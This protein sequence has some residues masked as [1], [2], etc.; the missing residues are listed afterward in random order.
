MSSILEDLNAPQREAV[1]HRDGPM[2]VVAGAGSGKTR[3]V[4]RRIAHLIGQGVPPRRILALTF[5]NKAAREMADRVEKLVGPAKTLVTTFH[6]ACARFLRFD[7]ERL[8]CGRDRRFSIY[9]EADQEAIIKSAVREL[10]LD[11]KQWPSRKL[12]ASISRFKTD[13]VGFEDALAAAY[14]PRQELAA[15]VY[16]RYEKKLREANALDFDDLLWVMLR[17]FQSDKPL[18]SEYQERYPDLL[19]DEYQDTNRV[20]YLLLKA[21][22]GERRNLHATGDPDQ[23]I[24]SWRGA[25]YRNIMDFAR[26]YPGTRLVLLEENYRS[27][28]RILN[29]S[30]RLIA[31]NARRYEKRLFTS[32]ALGEPVRLAHLPD[33]RAEAAWVAAEVKALARAGRSLREVAVFYRVNAQ[34]QPF[35]EVFMRETLPYAL[36]GGVRFYERREIKDL[37]AYLKAIQ[38]PRDNVSFRRLAASPPKGV[39]EKTLAALEALANARGQGMEAVLLREDFSEIWTGRL[40]AKLR[41]LRELCRALAGLPRAPVFPLVERVLALSGLKEHYKN[42]A[43]PRSDER[44]ENIEALVN[45]AAEF[46][47]DRPG[48]DLAAFLE[49]VALV[50]DVDEWDDTADRLTLMTMHAAKGL[51][52]AVVFVVGVE[53][54]LLPYGTNVESEAEKEEER[55]LFYVAMTRAREKLY[56]SA[57]A[58]RLQWGQVTVSLPSEFL[59]ELPEEDVEEMC[60]EDEAPAAAPELMPPMGGRA[61]CL[62]RRAPVRQGRRRLL[63]AGQPRRRQFEDLDEPWDETPLDLDADFAPGPGLG[64]GGDGDPLG[65]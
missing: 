36:V 54:R 40:S 57:A 6:S 2:L 3:V 13:M 23:S 42:L 46:D 29:V 51:E 41:A 55:R 21:L 39:G 10:D 60:L 11:S 20:Q 25:D 62:G 12:R 52:F 7:I 4:T 24:Y 58:Q 53:E 30:N 14:G 5:T 1:M 27:T 48:G 50:A 47:R 64:E 63:G 38:N 37:L 35:E 19:V 18:L 16:E 56:L 17:L 49:E 22:A 15:R 61:Y 34:S 65:G 28:K 44:T 43:D 31:H 32:N 45:R 33:D 59:Q 26:D 8:D 9:D